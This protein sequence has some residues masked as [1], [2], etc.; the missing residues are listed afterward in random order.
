MN[1]ILLIGDKCIDEY[2]HGQVDRISPEAPV[3]IFKLLY[4]ETKIGMAANVKENLLALGCEVVDYLS[5]ESVKI[6]L[7][8]ERS[9][10]HMLRIDKDV[11]SI[12][13]DIKD[14]K[15]FDVDAIVISDYNK[16]YITYEI[17]EKIRNR[18]PG[19]IFIDTKKQ[20]L[21]RFKGCY[22]KI[23][24]IEYNNKIS[25]GDDMIVTLG[26]NGT[27]Y[28]DVIYPTDKVEVNDVCGAGDTFLSALTAKFLETK[29]IIEAIKFANRC[30]SISVQH[31]G[32]Y[33]L[34]KEDLNG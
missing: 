30:A 16:G 28:K 19:P 31:N 24:E 10:Q 12:P 21:A 6:R 20:D 14:I 25:S 11:S 32:V 17:I 3:P 22:L 26:Q 29:D 13:L 23:N 8:D 5:G 7:I 15:D 33:V 34:T 27:L 9:K 4:Q 18:Y 2:W 1:R